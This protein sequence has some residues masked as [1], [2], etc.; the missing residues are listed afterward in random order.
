MPPGCAAKAAGA[1]GEAAFPLQEA[2]KA[3]LDGGDEDAVFDAGGRGGAA[4]AAQEQVVEGEEET[5]PAAAVA[6]LGPAA[7]AATAMI[8]A[9]ADGNNDHGDDD[10]DAPLSKRHVKAAAKLALAGKSMVAG[11]KAA[12]GNSAVVVAET[13]DS[14]ALACAAALA[15]VSSTVVDVVGLCEPCDPSADV[16]EAEAENHV[17]PARINMLLMKPKRPKKD[18]A[19]LTPAAATKTKTNRIVLQPKEKMDVPSGGIGPMI[20]EDAKDLDCSRVHN[21]AAGGNDAA[22]DMA[23]REEEGGGGGFSGRRRRRGMLQV[24]PHPRRRPHATV[25]WRA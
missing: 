9:V 15:T 8:R 14:P 11:K 2:T 6:A 20:A 25:R 1:K 16:D 4:A 18:K 21:D 7:D 23:I 12:A 13:A 22:Y 19:S 5:S 17:L 3:V 24:W 10:D